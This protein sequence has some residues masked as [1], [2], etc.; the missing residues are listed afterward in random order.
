MFLTYR[1]DQVSC[2]VGISDLRQFQRIEIK[3]LSIQLEE[4]TGCNGEEINELS[5]VSKVQIL[6]YQFQTSS[7][8]QV[9]NVILALQRTGILGLPI[10]I[11]DKLGDYKRDLHYFPSVKLRGQPVVTYEQLTKLKVWDFRTDSG[12]QF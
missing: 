2:L 1:F 8:N 3:P 11:R 7:D 10:L 5:Q 12:V 6:I 9:H 4:S